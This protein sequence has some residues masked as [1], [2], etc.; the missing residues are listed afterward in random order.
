MTTQNKRYI[1]GPW[2]GENCCY[3]CY[4]C[5]NDVKQA[6]H[7]NNCTGCPP[8]CCTC[9]PLCNLE[10]CITAHCCGTGNC[11]DSPENT[12]GMDGLTFTMHTA[13]WDD[14]TDHFCNLSNNPTST[15]V[16]NSLCYLEHDDTNC[17]YEGTAHPYE[18]WVNKPSAGNESLCD[19]VG[20]IYCKGSE[21]KSPTT[22][23]DNKGTEDFGGN[24]LNQQAYEGGSAAGCKGVGM[25]FSLCCCDQQSAAMARTEPY[26]GE[27]KTCSYQF[28]TEW[29]KRS[30]VTPPDPTLGSVCSCFD[31]QA[32][33]FLTAA[34]KIPPDQSAAAGHAQ[35]LSVVWEHVDGECGFSEDPSQ[36]F[37]PDDW[38]MTYRLG[39]A[40]DTVFWNCDC[41][42]NTE[43]FDPGLYPPQTDVRPTAMAYFT[44]VITPVGGCSK[45]GPDIP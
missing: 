17:P 36:P 42:F 44:A 27:C 7:Y 9:P 2:G 39:T 30:D 33:S 24:C 19:G 11:G 29:F 6:V 13:K 41:C 23:S 20:D 4:R 8:L 37:D 38:I 34:E 18:K 43:P 15:N 12:W 16:A 35:G 3:C 31:G 10:V 25:I 5:K 1:V 14:Y 45:G 21:G 40:E 22:D 28:R 32:G 26:E